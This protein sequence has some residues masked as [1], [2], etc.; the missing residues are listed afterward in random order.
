MGFMEN[1]DAK[2]RRLVRAPK[3]SE[4]LVSSHE[5]F[6]REIHCLNH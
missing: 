4:F 6:Y 2:R 5:K 1:A 3:R